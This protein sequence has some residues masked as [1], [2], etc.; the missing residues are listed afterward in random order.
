MNPIKSLIARAASWAGIPTTRQN[1]LGPRFEPINISA[2][3]TVESVQTAIRQAE[4]GETTALFRFYRDSL[5]GDDHVQGCLN[6][7][8]LAVIGQPLAILPAEPQNPDDVRAAAACL[9]AVED[10]DAWSGG[11]SA[12]LSASQWPVSVVENIFR[13]A[14]PRPV[15][16]RKVEETEQRGDAETEKLSE[17]TLQYTLKKLEPVNPMLHCYRHAYLVG[18]VGL[19]SA[20]PEMQAGLMRPAQGA[21]SARLGAANDPSAWYSIDLND[22]EPFLRLWPID[23]A[24]RIIYDASRASK[25]DPARHIV[26]RGH[27]LTEHRDNWG[28][29]M[30]AILF[31]WLLRGLGRDWFARFMERY[32]SPFPVAK[33]NVQDKE[34]VALLETA[35]S[36]STKIGG[37][38]IGQEDQVEL[39]AAAV[40]GGAEGHAIWNRVCNDAIARHITGY[41]SS[42]KPAGLNAGESNAQETVRSDIRIF[43]GKLLCETLQK[44]VFANFLRFNG[45]T[46][47]IRV[48]L[49]GLS[50]ADASTFAT[51]LKTTSEAGFEPTDAAMSGIEAKLGFAVQRKAAPEALGPQFGPGTKDQGP[52]T[53]ETEEEADDGEIETLSVRGADGRLRFFSAGGTPRRKPPQENPTAA[54]TAQRAAALAAAYKGV[55]AP[56]REIILSSHSQEEALTRL[57]AAYRDWKP[58]RLAAELETALQLCAAQGAAAAAAPKAEKRKS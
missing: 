32:G 55:M 27:L 58:E 36:L 42:D 30:R 11:L 2:T 28:G 14:D 56:F 18:G 13:P 5:L 44:Q 43:D 16:F 8:K 15:K 26:H 29:P 9:R 57:S 20:T 1:W 54:I 4:S 51:L 38:V 46:G 52:G 40:Q 19:G 34:A 3:A 50:T 7:R 12:L 39:Q 10:C 45:L 24:G 31:W 25:L 41:S 49:G 48:M 35:F 6:T 23:D 53:E 37:L 17:F 47:Q 33:T 21:P 22:W